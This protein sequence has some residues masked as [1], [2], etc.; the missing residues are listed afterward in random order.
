ML[1]RTLDWALA[2]T[3]DA[4]EL[5]CPHRVLLA[6]TPHQNPPPLPFAD[7]DVAMAWLA[8][9]HQQLVLLVDAAANAQLYDQTW[10]LVDAMWPLWQRLRPYTQWTRAHQIGLRAARTLNNRTAERRMLTSGAIGW[11]ASGTTDTA[12]T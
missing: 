9:H 2:A 12:L 8:D 5:L 1:R 3:I 7:Q 4:E 11:R 6:R 10:R